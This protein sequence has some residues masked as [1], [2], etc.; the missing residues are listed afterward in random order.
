M[1]MFALSTPILLRG[2]KNKSAL[3]EE[4]GKKSGVFI[5]QGIITAKSFDRIR[6]LSANHVSKLNISA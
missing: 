6:E 4:K 5:L 3:L 2:T 1:I